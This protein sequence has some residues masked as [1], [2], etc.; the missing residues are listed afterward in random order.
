MMIDSE[1]LFSKEDLSALIS[2]H[3][4]RLKEKEKLGMYLRCPFFKKANRSLVVSYRIPIY[5]L[6]FTQE[7]LTPSPSSTWFR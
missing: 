5:L 4:F 6:T 7:D 2:T 1:L 3:G